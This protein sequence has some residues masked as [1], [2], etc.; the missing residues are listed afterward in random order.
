M[1]KHFNF[2][3][4][5]EELSL[6]PSFSP[7]SI[8]HLLQ[9]SPHPRTID[10]PCGI[11]CMSAVCVFCVRLCVFSATSSLTFSLLSLPCNYSAGW[12]HIAGSLSI[13]VAR[14]R[15]VSGCGRWRLSLPLSLSLPPLHYSAR[16]SVTRPRLL[17]SP[18]N[19]ASSIPACYLPF[20]SQ[21]SVS[22]PPLSA[23]SCLR[24]EKTR[25]EPFGFM[26]GGLEA[27]RWGEVMSFMFYMMDQRVIHYACNES[28]YMTQWDKHKGKI[29]L[30]L[31]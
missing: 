16:S 22:S 3:S 2:L 28:F 12:T 5:L 13:S 27:P 18:Q 7:S 20:I 6:F 19:I 29:C 17:I 8:H 30:N 26:Q 4:K 9:M 24:G 11:L 21:L 23:L 25:Q 15:L 10:T 1:T 31:I 14:V